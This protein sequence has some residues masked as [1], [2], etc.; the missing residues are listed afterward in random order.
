MENFQFNP[1]FTIA[2]SLLTDS[3]IQ[4]NSEF[5]DVINEQIALGC[6]RM[7]TGRLWTLA[8]KPKHPNDETIAPISSCVLLPPE[9]VTLKHQP[10]YTSYTRMLIV[11]KQ[12]V[13][14]LCVLQVEQSDI[15]PSEM[16]FTI[17]EPP[18]FGHVVML[19]THA[20]RAESPVLDY[21]HTFTQDDVDEGRVLYVS[22]SQQVLNS[23]L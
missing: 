3:F 8:F 2:Y 17:K 20:D 12:N 1:H 22:A 7:L 23:E 16:V 15:L 18:R 11:D 19:V 13:H 10:R 14:L 9:H 5:C 4:S 6:S 21:I